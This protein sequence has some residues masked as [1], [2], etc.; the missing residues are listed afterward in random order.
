MAEVRVVERFKKRTVWFHW[1]H[2]ASFLVLLV[3]GAIL[4]L[5]G[6]GGSAAGGLTRSIHRI[7]VI[8]FVGI[9][10]IYFITSPRMSLHFIKET[11]TWGSN[12][13]Q[14]LYRAPDYYF[15]G[16]EEKMPPQGH[17]NTGQK[18]W[19]FIVVVTGVLFLVSGYIM[20]F[21]KDTLSPG[22]FQW[23]VIVHDIA[24]ILAFLMLLVHIYLGIIHPRMNESLR[25]MWDGKVSK[26]YA[27]NHY[28]K[29]YDEVSGG[30]S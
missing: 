15:G 27:R 16:D 7:A 23:F 3:T 22:V 20:W 29:W 12:D 8:F 25:S 4:F 2:T 6:L 1:I 9:P 11:F 18:M 30:K 14:W 24:F 21:Q 13:L 19:Q 17:V 5:P 26:T 10:I 28:G